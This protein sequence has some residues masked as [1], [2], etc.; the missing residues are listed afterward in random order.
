MLREDT[1]V[2]LQKNRRRYLNENT[3]SLIIKK[4]NIFC[5]CCVL[6]L[7]TVVV[8]SCFNILLPSS[9]KLHK[10]CELHNLWSLLQEKHIHLFKPLAKPHYK[11]SQS[12]AYKVAGMKGILHAFSLWSR[13]KTVTN[14]SRLT[15]LV[16]F[17][18]LFSS[19]VR[20]SMWW[21]NSV[22]REGIQFYLLQFRGFYSSCP[23]GCRFEVYQRRS[24]LFSFPSSSVCPTANVSIW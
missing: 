14:N 1:H 20:R 7:R 4:Q 8:S 11:A 13:W 16:R 24:I 18:C 9:W 3:R 10:T 19:V 12:Y 22:E 23:W 21:T 2:S 5:V 17:R 15:T 6:L